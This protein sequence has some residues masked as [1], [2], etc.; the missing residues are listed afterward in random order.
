MEAS[1]ANLVL[2]AKVRARALDRADR[3]RWDTEAMSSGAIMVAGDVAE[4][5]SLRG[6]LACEVHDHFGSYI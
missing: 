3:A 6:S 5:G 4:D 1:R 2:V